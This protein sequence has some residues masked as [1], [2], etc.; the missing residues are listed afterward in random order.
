MMHHFS[1][2]TGSLQHGNYLRCKAAWWRLTKHPETLPGRNNTSWTR[3]DWTPLS[4]Q[5]PG[6][7]PEGGGRALTTHLGDV[8][9]FDGRQLSR[10]DMSTLQGN[11][12][13]GE[14]RRD[15]CE[16][17]LGMLFFILSGLAF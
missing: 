2:N 5:Q 13:K 14:K 17:T 10:L 15:E 16:V 11:K 6:S 3:L 9:D 7:P 1:A 8:H 12:A 4:I